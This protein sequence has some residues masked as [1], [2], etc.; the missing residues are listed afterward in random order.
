MRK[1]GT[2][3]GV[4][5]RG[6]NDLDEEQERFPV[7][8]HEVTLEIEQ[9]L[10]DLRVLLKECLGAEDERALEALRG[11]VSGALESL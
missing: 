4:L 1:Y 3:A 11:R 6:N 9:G 10:A 7:R 8:V 2:I 5:K